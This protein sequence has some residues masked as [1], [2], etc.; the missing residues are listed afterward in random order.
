MIT[1]TLSAFAAIGLSKIAALAKEA[2]QRIKDFDAQAI[3]N[4]QEV[5]KTQAKRIRAS[6]PM[7]R[8]YAATAVSYT[9]EVKVRLVAALHD[10]KAHWLLIH[11]DCVFYREQL[12]QY[13]I[14]TRGFRYG[15]IFGKNKN[16]SKSIVDHLYIKNY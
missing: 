13:D 11:S 9:G 2:R 4:W 12:A 15:Q 3:S 7:A 10:T 16:H 14:Q 1:K 5:P 6:F 8:R